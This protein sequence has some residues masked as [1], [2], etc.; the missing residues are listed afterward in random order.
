MNKEKIFEALF[1]IPFFIF[2]T[3][4]LLLLTNLNLPEIFAPISKVPLVFLVFK[5]IIQFK[6]NLNN[7][8][9]LIPW[10]VMLIIGLLTSLIGHQN[11][12]L[13]YAIFAVGAADISINK[14]LKIHFRLVGVVMSII[15]ILSLLGLIENETSLRG[16]GLMRF[17][18]GFGYPSITATLISFTSIYWIFGKSKLKLQD[19]IIF[20]SVVSL[21]YFVLNSRVDV[22]II[23]L[24]YFIIVSKQYGLLQIEWIR[25]QK[26]YFVYF[27]IFIFITVLLMSSYYSQN[28]PLFDLMD[29]ILSN[30]LMLGHIAL[31]NY[32]VTLFGQIIIMNG[33]GVFNPELPYFYID[34]AYLQL[35]LM[36]GL[37][38]TSVWLLGQMKLLKES[39]YKDSR[40]F[41][42]LMMTLIHGIIAPAMIDP[43]FNPLA[44]L[45][46]ATIEGELLDEGKID[47]NCNIKLVTHQVWEK[48][49]RNI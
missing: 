34:S 24:A 25:N 20:M 10:S 33:Y 36:F 30:R 17:S 3:I 42:M 13:Y 46:F 6:E 26:K 19:H 43:I 21:L 44:V 11:F 5:I 48:L 23:L 31:E 37:A 40:I 41:Y 27:P 49:I 8:N 14:V 32:P 9:K 12:P 1:L 16:D 35:I 38:Y 45:F 22:I 4:N 28:I 18:L 39:M 29:K 2:V 15:I 7:K 47:L